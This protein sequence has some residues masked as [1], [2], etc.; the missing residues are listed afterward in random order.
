MR[1]YGL[2]ALALTAAVERHLGQDLGIREAELAAV[3]LEAVHS[4]H[5]AE[6]L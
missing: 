4:D 2:D 1:E 5:K 6:A 3:R